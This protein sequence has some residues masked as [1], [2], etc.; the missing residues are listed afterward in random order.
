MPWSHVCGPVCPLHGSLRDKDWWCNIKRAAGSTKSSSIPLLVTEDGKEHHTSVEKADCL[1][2]FYARKCSLGDSE[3][4]ESDLPSLPVHDLPPIHRIHFQS[5]TARCELSRL[6]PPKATGS[7]GIPA[8]VLKECCWD[9][10]SPG[11]FSA[12]CIV[13]QDWHCPYNVETS[14]C[15]PYK[16]YKKAATLTSLQLSSRVSVTHSLKSNGVNCQPASG[17]LMIPRATQTSA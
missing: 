2:Q 15:C 6:V 4:R 8:R 12:V 17:E 1:A 3:L 9:L 13:F 16:F 7:D 11:R 14:S 5:D 10:A